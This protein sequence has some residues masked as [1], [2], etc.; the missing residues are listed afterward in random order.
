MRRF[1][2]AGCAG[3]GSL[4]SISC[5]LGCS[6]DPPP[7]APPA[8]GTVVAEMV[9]HARPRLRSMTFSK[10]GAHASSAAPALGAQSLDDLP[11]VQ[12]GNPGSGPDSSVELVTNTVGDTF[13]GD[14]CPGVAPGSK[15]FCANVTLNHF[16]PRPLSNVFVQ[17][18]SILDGNL[19]PLDAH[20]AWISDPAAM[21][22]GNGLGLWSYGAPGAAPG[23][24]GVSP[25]NG[26]S[27][28]WV[29]Q[30]PDD[31]DTVMAFRVVSSL[32]YT[33]YDRTAQNLPFVNACDSGT[34]LGTPMTSVID[35]PFPFTLYDT[36]TSKATINRRGVLLMG[37][38]GLIAPSKSVALPASGNVPS[39][40][41]FN[42]CA[43]PRPAIF[44]FWDILT[45]LGEG[46]VCTLTS[47]AAPSRTFAVT[48][49][50]LGRAGSLADIDSDYTFTVVLHE[51]TD[52]IDLLYGPMFGALPNAAG[53]SATIGVQNAAGTAATAE[54]QAANYGTGTSYTFT[55]VP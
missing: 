32:T 17:V 50:H 7:P 45:Y 24:L 44:P 51:G 34:S 36:T 3:A 16:Y 35:L 38:N 41:L 14:S 52:V 4:L 25:D 9:A 21:G 23:V 53:G 20:E 27:R 49:S 12:D 2:R 22:L 46:G 47:G 5:A 30:N 1:A 43:V 42:Q 37:V 11:I 54:W 18:T 8:R 28:D 29:F 33:S 10:A 40:S 48:W 55:P 13:M 15:A 6:A 19:Q 31:A 26:G 39:C